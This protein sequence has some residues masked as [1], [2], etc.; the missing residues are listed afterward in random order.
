MNKFFYVLAL[1]RLFESLG[2]FKLLF[3]ITLK[4]IIFSYRR[5][6][7]LK[8]YFFTSFSEKYAEDQNIITNSLFDY[9]SLSN[10]EIS[11]KDELLKNKF[12]IF[13][14]KS[15]DY[16]T[17]LSEK[18][19]NI[20]QINRSNRQKS[21]K[22]FENIITPFKRNTYLTNWYYDANSKFKWKA[23]KKSNSLKIQYNKGFD[24]KVPWELSRLQSL[25]KIC[26]WSFLNKK[27][28]LYTFI[29]NQVFDFIASNPPSYG[30]NWFNAMEVAIRGAN[31]CMITDILV[32][33]D[34]LSPRER[35][36]V[37]NSINDHIN[38]VI[39]NLEWSPFSRN[40]H[41]LANIVGLLVMAYFLPRD[42]Y[43]LGILKFA[44]N[45][46]FNEI[47][48]QFYND[49]GNKEGSSAY[50]ILSVEIILIGIYL[51]KK[52][53]KEDSMNKAVIKKNTINKTFFINLLSDDVDK[54]YKNKIFRKLENIISFSMEMKRND[55]SLL[56]VGDNDSG[57]FFDLDFSIESAEK[58]KLHLLTSLNKKGTIYNLIMKTIKVKTLHTKRFKKLIKKKNP[59]YYEK[60]LYSNSYFFKFHKN[61]KIK[62][63]KL[64]YFKDFGIFCYSHKILKLFVN[65]KKNFDQL[66][67]GHMHYDNLSIDF[68]FNKQNVV[69]DPGNFLYSSDTT[70]R[71][72]FKSLE[73]HFCPFFNNS[74]KI[75]EEYTFSS[76]RF[77]CAR[78]ISF[79]KNSFI[80]EIRYDEG[81]ITRVIQ[82]FENGLS[83]K[84]Y[85]N[86][87]PIK[88]LLKSLQK[89]RISSSYGILSKRKIINKRFL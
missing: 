68:S 28:N 46:L 18:I 35:K 27:K 14:E 13:S 4:I 36:V 43:T 56:Q 66:N 25:S 39:N 55:N 88:N 53:D 30:V 67:S 40:N 45:Q 3:F 48:Y 80:G 42:E 2:F 15:E 69:A 64:V 89:K 65:C 70:K 61:I 60:Y 33:E 84:D 9:K 77:F 63:I 62:D 20:S 11:N 37:Y 86:D 47:S 83:I 8:I 23:S 49:G 16:S 12:K 19:S 81:K 32:Q 72:D 6:Y 41:Y 5:I 73:M 85:S 78:A 1:K 82:F 44:E 74:E 59:K 76:S 10:F 52:L 17:S 87:K 79:D 7:S 54:K 22:I 34:K 57:C 26:V 21:K 38:F 29:K 71:S 24:I 58:K 50:H 51:S 31:L 75:S